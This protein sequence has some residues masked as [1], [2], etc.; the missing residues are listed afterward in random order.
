[1]NGAGYG[2]GPIEYAN[3]DLL[4]GHVSDADILNEI[5]SVAPVGIVAWTN[6]VS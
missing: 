1:M 6:I 5:A 4:N 3:L 2:G